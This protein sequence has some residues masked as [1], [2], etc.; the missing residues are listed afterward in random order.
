MELDLPLNV[1]I[2]LSPQLELRPTGLTRPQAQAATGTGSASGSTSSS[3][4]SVLN[5]LK[6]CHARLS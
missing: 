2:P 3:S 1:C 5:G 4:I 6:G